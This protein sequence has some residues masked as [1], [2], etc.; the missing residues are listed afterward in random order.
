[1]GTEIGATHKPNQELSPEALKKKKLWRN[2]FIFNLCVTLLL[3]G[4]FWLP[5][6]LTQ[7]NQF[8]DSSS[9]NQSK[10][11]GGFSGVTGKQKNLPVKNVNLLESKNVVINSTSDEDW[12]Y[13]DFS[14][15]KEVKIHDRSSLEW[16]LAFRR[17]KIVTNGGATNKFG[18]GGIFSLGEVDFDA[19]E[20]VPEK[21][22]I[23]DN[24]TRT[25]TENEVLSQWYKYNYLTHKL[26]PRK[27][28]YLLQT[29]DRKFAKIQFLS[30]YCADKQP[31][32]IQMK[33]VYQPGGNKSFLKN[34]AV[35]GSN[36]PP[37]SPDI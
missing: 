28:I 21:K 9:V 11:T 30:F 3:I 10:K 31:G 26:T 32:C 18:G 13:F 15:G 1:M 16:D 6:K 35:N 20:N 5:L 22:F 23:L 12:T 27:N 37:L 24:A 17:G 29:A 25:E 8:L 34:T 4:F 19:V 33:Y 7:I 14:R 2:L 36:Q